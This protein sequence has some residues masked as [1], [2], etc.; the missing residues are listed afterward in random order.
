M[1][2][3]LQ[4]EAFISLRW[5]TYSLFSLSPI[6]PIPS[7]FT[8]LGF[9]SDYAHVL[10]RYSVLFMKRYVLCWPIRP[11]ALL[12]IPSTIASLVLAWRAFNTKPEEDDD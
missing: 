4:K 10:K 12:Y 1:G 9:Y 6:K 2:T 8:S 7:F 3:E 11:L 5:L